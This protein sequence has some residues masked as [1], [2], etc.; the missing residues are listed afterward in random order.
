MPAAAQDP[1]T[2]EK[3]GVV[4]SVL[5]NLALVMRAFGQIFAAKDLIDAGTGGGR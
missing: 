5:T 2:A 4:E 3:L 1:T